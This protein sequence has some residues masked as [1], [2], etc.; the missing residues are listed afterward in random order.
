MAGRILND[1]IWN[2]QLGL[3]HPDKLQMPI[4][5]VGAGSIGSWTALALSKLGCSNVTIMDGDVIEEHNAGSQV[6]KASDEGMEKVQALTEK[7]R[8]LTDLMPTP[9]PNHW[10]IENPEHIKELDKYQIIISAVDNITVR[11]QL[12]N[13]LKG[14]NVFYID[15]RMAGNALEIYM[16]KCDNEEDLKIYEQTLF[17]AEEET[18]VPCS[19]RSV[20]YNVFIMGGLITDVVKKYANGEELPKELIMDLY[21]FTLYK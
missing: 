14:K 4:L 20:V 16:T 15:G 11:A 5:I 9:V 17:T 7:L 13:T 6:Y 12:F 10:N 21:N 1:N 2:R 3:I 8:F 19:E 18:P